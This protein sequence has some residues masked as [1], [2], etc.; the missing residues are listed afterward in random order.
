MISRHGKTARKGGAWS[1]CG[2]AAALALVLS[3]CAPSSAPGPT[4]RSEAPAN[5]AKVWP[6]DGSDIPPDPR[7]RYGRLGNGMR[8]ALMANA[9]P[10][11]TAALRLRLDAGSV[12]EAEDQRGLAH[13]LEHMA[14]NGSAH[15]AEGEMIK[16]LERKGLAFGP[17]TNAYTS[18]DETVYQLDLPATDAET[19]DTGLFLLRET[20]DQLLIAP[21]GVERER[22]VVL[23]EHRGGETWARRL[24]DHQRAFLYPKT[25]FATRRPIGE[26]AV[27]SGAP[28]ERLRALYD[29]YYRPE[30]ALL[31]AT[32][33]FDVAAMERKIAERFSDWRGRGA[34]GPEAKLGAIAKRKEAAAVFVDPDAPTAVTLAVVK[35]AVIEPDTIATRQVNLLRGIG[36]G[37]LSR[38]LA[39]LARKPEATFLQGSASFGQVF[40]LADIAQVQI[41]SRPERWREALGVAERELRRARRHG[42]TEAE[43]AEQVANLHVALKNAAD[44]SKTRRTPALADGIAGAIA[45]DQVFSDPVQALARFEGFMADITPA[46]VAKAFEERWQGGP[47]LVHLATSQ[48]VEGGER[49]VL[50]ALAE[51]RALAVAAPDARGSE[52]FAYDAF[53]AP[54]AIAERGRID[55]LDIT[56]VTFANGV[57]LN[58]K[59]TPFQDDVIL[60]SLRLG[61]GQLE[62]AQA[63]EGLGFLVGG[64]FVGGGLGKHSLDELERI[65]AGRSVGVGF[66]AGDDAY[67]T[68]LG[69][70]P[71]DLALQLKV[72]AAYVADPAYRP[73]GEAQFRQSVEVWYDTLDATPQGVAGRFLPRLLRGGD[74]RWGIPARETLLARTSEELARALAPALAE[75]PIEIGIVGDVDIEAAIAATAASFGALPARATANPD[76]AAARAVSFP[77]A[78]GTTSTLTHKGEPDRALAL[79]HWPT[80]DDGDIRLARRL[81]L[82]AEVL[83]LKLIET[84][85][86]KEGASY[87]PSAGS[88][89]SSVFPGYGYVSASLELKPEDVARFFDLVDELA[90]KLGAGEISADE[91]ERAR[92]PVLEQIEES[93]ERNGYWLS[94]AGAA[95]GDPKRLAHHRSAKADIEAITLGDLVATAKT[96]LRPE[97]AYR[98]AVMPEAAGSRNR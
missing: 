5:A 94:L 77:K 39:T 4:A 47:V 90:A 41:V 42:F 60:V 68:S 66:G 18:Y 12:N 29:G 78:D 27:I 80:T 55:D 74:P 46:A 85:R 61:A 21:D 62:L 96:Y 91:L 28:A 25:A 63:P 64:A 3:A 13:F 72:L 76:F 10:S 88:H 67:G 97:R 7:V 54:G 51:S 75:G 79:I 19:I 71:A 14:F 48:A 53:G 26:A 49:A 58:V 93:L 32:G 83:Q 56:T 35:P 50:A 59:A 16:I 17:D 20:A 30:R 65:L 89:A 45:D 23:A 36:A 38:R 95:Q 98:V 86:E 43:I 87:S 8:Y 6:H 84:A 92:Q 15:V 37:V 70:T 11:K 73:E 2:L 40:E 81:G 1:L 34:A 9:T 31:V 69:T 52:A 33:D 82:L 22:G 57:R 44:Q 24:G